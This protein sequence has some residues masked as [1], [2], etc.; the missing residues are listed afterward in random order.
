M[1]NGSRI[2][3]GRLLRDRE[4][5]LHAVCAEFQKVDTYHRGLITSSNF[6]KALASL[7]LQYGQPEV[8]DLLQ[9]CQV[10]DDG[11][12]HYKE[13][14]AFL[15]PQQPRAKQSSLKQT[16]YP[17]EVAAP[18]P[19]DQHHGFF[20]ARTEDIRKVYSLWE[21]GRISNDQFKDGLQSAGAPSPLPE[22][23]D[24]L[25]VTYGPARSLPFSKLMYA[26]Q[27]DANDGRRARNV[28]GV[29]PAVFSESRRAGAAGGAPSE[30]RFHGSCLGP[31][32]ST[33]SLCDE[34]ANPGS[35]RQALS[36]FVDGLIP[37]VT[38]RLQLQRFGVALTPELEK[39]IR[40]H[41][42]DSSVRFQDFARLLLRQESQLAR[43]YDAVPGASTPGATTPRSDAPSRRGG[44]PR[45]YP[46]TPPYYEPEEPQRSIDTELA[47]APG[48]AVLPPYALTDV[49]P[50]QSSNSRPES[51]PARLRPAVG[52]HGDILGWTQAEEGQERAPSRR[53]VPAPARAPASSFLQWPQAQVQ[54]EAAPAERPGRRLYGRAAS[55]SESAP[56]GRSCDASGGPGPGAAVTHAAS[57]PF[58]GAV[59]SGGA[60]KAP[61]GTDR[62]LQLRRPEDAG[63]D[64]Y[65]A[66]LGLWRR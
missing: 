44:P 58:S 38:F 36:D 26:L 16:L 63:T 4:Y 50:G 15:S 32:S 7:G 52:G 6:A 47:R 23:L 62:D 57:A 33:A 42:S 24:R 20:V 60:R 64:E 35:L 10:T 11:Y 19:Q 3:R 25:L 28:L 29:P 12:V 65:R 55:A 39:R 61:F 66:S 22:E 54:Q 46:V 21:R 43:E 45:G 49:E 37:A 8:D 31:P 1:A 41:E 48:P 14:S 17:A 2:D 51:Q 18:L 59:G 56:F 53:R 34:L 30:L 9:Y 5:L 40:T 27:I 13:L